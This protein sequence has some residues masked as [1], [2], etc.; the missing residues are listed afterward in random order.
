MKLESGLEA[1]SLSVENKQI[2]MMHRMLDLLNI[3][4]E[5]HNLTR[6]LKREDQVVYHILDSL[7]AHEY[8]K[9][10]Q[11]IMD[12]GT[13]AGF[14]SIPLAIIYPEK[15]FHLVESNGKKIAYL[16]ML[17]KDL[18]LNNVKLYHDRIEKINLDVDVITAR[19][20]ASVDSILKL[21]ESLSAN[22]ILYVSKEVDGSK[23][24]IHSVVVPGS[25]KTHRIFEIIK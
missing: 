4:N 9:P 15:M 5:R 23:G 14:P 6:Y 10:Y 12:I 19:A 21:T 8:F 11:E 20:L 16:R 7:S 18:S 13:G 2:E 22:Y 3:W 17:V 25:E 24:V 1:L